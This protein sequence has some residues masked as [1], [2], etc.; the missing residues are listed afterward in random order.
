[1]LFINFSAYCSSTAF[2]PEQEVKEGHKKGILHAMTLSIK[3][4]QRRA[5]KKENKNTMTANTTTVELEQKN[6]HASASDNE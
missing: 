1:M 6:V 5:L 4:L 3:Q 2:K